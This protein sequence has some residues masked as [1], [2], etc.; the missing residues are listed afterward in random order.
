MAFD[1]LDWN[2]DPNQPWYVK[3]SDV[4]SQMR[5]ELF[6]A[7]ADMDASANRV[8]SADIAF[9]SSVNVTLTADITQPAYGEPLAKFNTSL[10]YHLV[11]AGADGDPVKKF[12]IGPFT[13]LPAI[14]DPLML[15]E[16]MIQARAQVEINR[17]IHTSLMRSF[18]LDSHYPALNEGEIITLS[19]T[20]RGLSAVR[21]RVESLIIRAEKSENDMRLADSLEVVEFKD[22]KR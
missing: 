5:L 14:E 4:G 16:N 18:A 8:A 1:I 11:A 17:A 13:D 9:G 15:S 2:V 6:N 19:S 12:L 20:K 22:V 10:S 21:C 3:L 7:Q